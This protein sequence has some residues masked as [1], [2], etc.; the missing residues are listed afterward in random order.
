[1]NYQDFYSQK[2]ITPYISMLEG[3]AQGYMNPNSFYNQSMYER[4][5]RAGQ[6]AAGQ[7]FQQG[8]K[9]QSAGVNPFANQQ[10]R[11][12][13]ANY[14]DQAMNNWQ[15]GMH[16]NQQLGTGMLGMGLQARTQHS[17][18]L[19]Q[20]KQWNREYKQHRTGQWLGLAGTLGSAALLGGGLGGLFPILQA[21]FNPS[22]TPNINGPA[23]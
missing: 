4:Y 18:Q 14:N 23:R 8:M 9:M 16:G 21:L 22:R 2:E 13:M 1:M 7:Q 6:D 12:N 15:Q 5:K 20:Q 11:A 3:I 10:Y 19:Q 17:T